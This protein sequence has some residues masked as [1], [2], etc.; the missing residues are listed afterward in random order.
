MW[1][2]AQH[3]HCRLTLRDPWYVGSPAEWPLTDQLANLVSGS[4][5]IWYNATSIA[6]DQYQYSATLVPGRYTCISWRVNLR[7]VCDPLISTYYPVRAARDARPAWPSACH[8]VPIAVA[9]NHLPA[10]PRMPSSC[11]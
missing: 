7:A 2:T 6:A 5:Y 8:P 3:S 11:V 9:A 1:R 4:L 10:Q